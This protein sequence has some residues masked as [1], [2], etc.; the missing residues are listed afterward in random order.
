[1]TRARLAFALL[2]VASLA[3]ATAGRAGA[4]LYR[5]QGPDGRIVFSD[6]PG[7]CPGARPHEP[8]DVVQTLPADGAR[9]APP[10]AAVDEPIRALREEAEQTQAAAW[11][12]RKA[13]KQEEL[14]S[15]EEREAKFQRYTKW[16]NKG[17]TLFEKDETTGLKS[18]VECEDVRAELEQIQA[19]QAG[20]REYLERGIHE[21]CRRAGCLPGWLR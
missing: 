18:R 14:R 16:C 6:N 12:E 7:A 5:C 17:G 20:V 8:A 15:L 19:A 9:A 1:M 3:A 2:A 4:D 13:A 21:E 10:P 11:R